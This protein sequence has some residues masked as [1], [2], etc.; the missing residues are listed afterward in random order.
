MADE[1]LEIK[2]EDDIPFACAICRKPFVDPIV[3]KCKHYFCERCAVQQAKTDTKCVICGENTYGSFSIVKKAIREK[4][5]KRWEEA[6]ANGENLE[7]GEEEEDGEQGENKKAVEREEQEEAGE[8]QQ[9]E[10]Q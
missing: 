9:G 7:G 6:L 8:E 3:T 4:M 2:E 5:Q 10:T 1:D